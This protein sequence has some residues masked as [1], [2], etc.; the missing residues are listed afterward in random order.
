MI[1]YE[2]ESLIGFLLDYSR[3]LTKKQ[4]DLNFISSFL[5]S[6]RF[7]GFYFFNSKHSKSLEYFKTHNLNFFFFFFDSKKI[8]K[9]I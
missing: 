4:W 6:K 7:S 2:L 8:Y 1:L 3:I 5:F 9:L